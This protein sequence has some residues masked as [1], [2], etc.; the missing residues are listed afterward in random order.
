MAGHFIIG[1]FVFVCLGMCA[2]HVCKE[3]RPALCCIS[4]GTG[5]WGD[6]SA[7]HQ[8]RCSSA[9]LTGRPGVRNPS[10]LNWQ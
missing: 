7:A 9:L 8:G 5:V 1:C 2:G 6:L 3:C 4:K 10:V